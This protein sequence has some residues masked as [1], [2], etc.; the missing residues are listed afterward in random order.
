MGLSKELILEFK[1]NAGVELQAQQMGQYIAN[2][3][4]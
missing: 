1:G 4:S 3:L 2:K